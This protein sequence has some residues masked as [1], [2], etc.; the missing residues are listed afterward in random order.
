MIHNGILI[1][2]LFCKQLI[3]FIQEE[4][5]S[6]KATRYKRGPRAHSAQHAQHAFKFCAP[7]SSLA[8]IYTLYSAPYLYKSHL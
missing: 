7:S 3:I 8:Q 6:F 1:G 2:F 5:D 4:E